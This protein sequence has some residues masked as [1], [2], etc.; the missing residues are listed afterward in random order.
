MKENSET[1]NTDA[2]FELCCLRY[3]CFYEWVAVGGKLV[4][5][6]LLFVAPA[7]D[8]FW[9]NKLESNPHVFTVCSL[10]EVH[11]CTFAATLKL[12]GYIN[13]PTAPATS[14]LNLF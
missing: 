4:R 7:T 5:D 13:V 14:L 9:E 1:N 11:R 8:A 2:R 10:F 12:N 6:H 3:V